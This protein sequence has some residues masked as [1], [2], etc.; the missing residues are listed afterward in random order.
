M[1]CKILTVLFLILAVSCKKET[2]KASVTEDNKVLSDTIQDQTDG[3]VVENSQLPVFPKSGK[4]I[5][6]FLLEPYKVQ[7]EAEG[8]LNDDELEDIVLVLQNKN[9]NT[10]VRP[11]LVLIKQSSGGYRLQETSWQAL[12]PEYSYEGNKIYDYEDITIGKDKTLTVTL[13]GIGPVG[14]QETT[15]K[16]VNNELIFTKIHVFNMGAGSQIAV[17]YDL[18]S[19]TAEMELVNTMVDSMPSTH[20]TKKFKLEKQLFVYDSPERVLKKLPA[21]DW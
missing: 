6:D 2:E 3:D 20:E 12:N 14:T 1:K 5:E 21:T 17:D 13:N 8:F 15:Y 4:K 10:D 7:Y 11:T 9:D 18:I 16:Y 19:G